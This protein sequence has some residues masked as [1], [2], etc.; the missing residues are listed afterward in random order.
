M[1]DSE[2]KKTTKPTMFK[3]AMVMAVATMLSRLFGLVR[4]QLIAAYFGASGLTD[5]FFVAYRIPNLFRDLFA[6]GAFSAAFVPN[7]VKARHESAETARELLWEL[8]F[9]LVLIVGS[10]SLGITV[11]AES[12]VDLFAPT[13]SEDLQKFTI[14][15]GLTKIMA[16]FILWTSLAALVMGALNSLKVFF[17]PAIAPAFFNIIVIISI[18]VFTSYLSAQ[19]VQPIYALGLGVLLGGIGQFIIQIPS[20]IKHGYGPKLP[21]KLFTKRAQEVLL[22]LG[23]GLIGFAAT[24]FNLIVNTI[25]ASMAAVGA[26]SWLSYGFRLFQLPV[27]ILGV[28]LG[29]SNLVYFADAYKAQDYKKANHVLNQSYHFALL[30][31]LPVTVLTMIFAR[32]IV[33][34]IFQRG[35]FDL[36]STEM[37]TK[38][39]RWYALGLPCYGLYKIFVPVFYTLN[40]AKLPVMTSIAGIVFNIAFCVYFTPKYGFEWLA[41]G[42]SMSMVLNVAV[43][44]LFLKRNLNLNLSFFFTIRVLKFLL[45]TFL[46]GWLGNY[47]AKSYNFLEGNLFFRLISVSFALAFCLLCYIFVLYIFGERQAID[48]LLSRLRR[49]G[50]GI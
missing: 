42:T 22:L 39:L 37:T 9:I 36:F 2:T 31:L 5:A 40:K 13:F 28:S 27:G 16:S 23:P 21:K 32:D 50:T 41:I 29:N 47:I 17:L 7:F 43:Q 48:N 49:K 6:E 8:F 33:S 34:L 4:E 25:L 11:G 30:L 24:Q 18:I 15:V 1:T 14:A 44:S 19:G 45:A 10:I 38:A 12:L 26:V 46:T 20:I 3:S 35:E